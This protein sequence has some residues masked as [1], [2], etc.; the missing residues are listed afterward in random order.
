MSCIVVNTS[1]HS[2]AV[3]ST[4]I[5][6]VAVGSEKRNTL[7]A[8]SIVG[9]IAQ[10]ADFFIRWLRDCLARALCAEGPDHSDPARVHPFWYGFVLMATR[11]DAG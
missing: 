7:L 11:D 9:R 1:D 10:G 6:A 2:A 3:T 4:L 8:W 5:A